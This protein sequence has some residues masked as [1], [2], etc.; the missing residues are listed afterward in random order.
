MLW[1]IDIAARILHVHTGDGGNAHTLSLQAEAAASQAITP[2]AEG[3]AGEKDIG[4][5]IP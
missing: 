1:T 2:G 4:L 5:I 3:W